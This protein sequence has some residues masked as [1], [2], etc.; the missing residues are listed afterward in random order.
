MYIH[1]MQLFQHPSYSL[2][3]HM[4]YSYLHQEGIVFGAICL[5]VCSKLFL[6]GQLNSGNQMR[7]VLY[8]TW[9]KCVGEYSCLIGWQVFVKHC[10]KHM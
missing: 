4:L 5:F 9:Y 3:E 2:Y 1:S 8:D 10:L 6:H 7:S